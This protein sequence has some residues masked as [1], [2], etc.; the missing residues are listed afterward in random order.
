MSVMP[1]DDGMHICVFESSQ[2]EGSYVGDS[3]YGNM[4]GK[5]DCSECQSTWKA[6][7]LLAWARQLWNI[8][9]PHTGL[10]KKSFRVFPQ[11]LMNKPEGTFWPIQ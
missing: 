7:S 4:P 2:L 9:W 6:L 11:Q 3:L 5:G 8:A 1:D 10:T